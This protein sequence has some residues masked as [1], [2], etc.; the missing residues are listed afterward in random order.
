MINFYKYLIFSCQTIL[1]GVILYFTEHPT[2]KLCSI[3]ILLTTVIIICIKTV[4]DKVRRNQHDIFHRISDRMH[5]FLLESQDNIKRLKR[6]SNESFDKVDRDRKAIHGD[7]Q[8]FLKEPNEQSKA[9]VEMKLNELSSHLQIDDIT[10]QTCDYVCGNM[11]VYVY[12]LDSYKHTHIEGK[13]FFKLSLQKQMESLDD[14]NQQIEEMVRIHSKSPINT[15]SLS[16]GD[17][18]MF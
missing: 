7:L 14:L 3:G 18:E 17:V 12:F 9:A 6:L 5:D 2:V 11:A 13:T 15:D 4:N 8:A 10:T 16:D 1:S